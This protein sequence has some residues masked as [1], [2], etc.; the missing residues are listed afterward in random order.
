V[1]RSNNLWFGVCV[2]LLC[3]LFIATL[4]TVITYLGYPRVVRAT[5]AALA[6]STIV[7][8]ALMVRLWRQKCAEEY[9][10]TLAVHLDA[11]AMKTVIQVLTKHV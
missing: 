4:W 7:F 6:V 2:A 3:I 9:L 1:R 10:I 11:A 5:V 8:V